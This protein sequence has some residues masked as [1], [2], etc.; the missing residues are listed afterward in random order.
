MTGPAG[1][2]DSV[3]T[4]L[5]ARVRGGKMPGAAWWT[6]T[7]GGPVS[8]GALG[9]AVLDP[10]REPATP[11]TPFDLAS[12]AKPLGTAILAT[13]LA[14]EGVLSFND[15]IARLVP[16]VA[17]SPYAEITLRELGAHRG[18][19]PA[20]RPLY[21]DAGDAASYARRIAAEPPESARGTTLY[22]DLGYLLLGFAI[23]RA[24]GG[25]L[26]ALFEERVARR[27]GLERTG[28]AVRGRRYEDAAATERGNGYERRL[29]GEAGEGY[30]W[31]ETMI[32][33]AVHDGNAWGLGG[34]AGH[35]GLFG[36]AEEVARIAL[37][38]LRPERL[39]LDRSSRDLWLHPAGGAGGRTFG[40]LLAHDSDSARGILEDDAIGHLGFTG[41]SV[42]VEPATGR[43]HVLLTN[44]VHPEVPSEEFTEVRRG[45]H[46]A[47]AGVRPA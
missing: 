43:V 28:Y 36:T 19:L 7:E 3:R 6:G 40:W 1:S 26:D 42:F 2:A 41:T 24:A 47:A 17:G 9:F 4:F 11:S 44:R 13:G 27:L 37:A 18:G 10:V 16:E 22:S 8:S 30:A 12:L 38:V 21:L 34:V 14:E 15:P 5:D 35:A 46:A 45:F 29:A 39:G 23:E 31:R 33:G 25:T 32:R 20:W